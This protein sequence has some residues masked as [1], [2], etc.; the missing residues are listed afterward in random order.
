MSARTVNAKRT[1][2]RVRFVHLLCLTV[3]LA[4]AGSPPAGMAYADE[5]VHPAQP[6]FAAV[7]EATVE[8]P[9]NIYGHGTGFI[10]PRMELP[11]LTGQTMPETFLADGAPIELPMSFDW[12][13][14]GKVTSVKNQGVC[15]SCYAFAA[16]ANIE[17]EILIDGAAMLPDPDY[18]ENNAKECNWRELNDFINRFGDPVGGCD[19]GNYR[20]LAS[21]FSQTGIV[22]EACDPYVAG[23]SEPC[24]CSCP[25]EKTLLDWRII[26]GG[27]VADTTLLKNY[28]YQQASPVYV[29]I[30]A[31]SDYDPAWKAEFGLYDGSYTLYYPSCPYG[32][33]HAVLIVG[34]DD[35]LVHDGGTGGW[36]VKNSWGTSWGGDCGYGSEGGYFT[37]AYGSANIGRSASYMAEWQDYD[38][39]GGIL[40]YDDDC[41][42]DGAWRSGSAPTTTWGLCEFTPTSSTYATRVEFWTTD[43]TTDIDVYL[44]DDFDGVDLDNSNLLWSSLNHS[45]EEAG[46][47]GIDVAPPVPISSAAGITAV[48]AFTNETFAYPIAC[49]ARG[50]VETSR[51]YIS[52]DGS[53]D[54]WYDTGS[55]EDHASD[56]GIRVR[57][58]DVCDWGD[59]PDEPYP[60]LHTDDGA[61]HIVVN[62]FHLGATI[63]REGD[64]QP[65]ADATGDDSDGSDDDDGVV[66]TS[67]YLP[68]HDMTL[69]VAASQAGY[70][71]AW[72][73]FNADGDWADADEQVFASE[74]LAQGANSLAFSVPEGAST[75]GDI[76][77]R[78]RFSSSGGLSYTGEAGDGE[79]EDYVGFP[80]GIALSLE[81]GWN[82]VSTPVVPD[83]DSPEALFPCAEAIYA[84]APDTH[85][86]L[87]VSA[88]G[89]LTTIEPER[90]YWVALTEDATLI[91]TGTPVLQMIDYPL[92]TGWSMV[93]SIHGQTVG[94]A[95]LAVDPPGAIQ[96]ESIY[97]WNPSTKSFI[98]ASEIEPGKGYWIAASEPCNLTM[99]PP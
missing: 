67:S 42:D 55:D 82:M 4:A 84:W 22:A 98:P 40:Y 53:A 11:H 2:R 75:A 3:V 57:T 50:T 88:T 35:S 26:S 47:H 45:F 83:D 49:D 65:N 70:L 15:G 51:C 28:I 8:S 34:W 38:E 39:H 59:A 20:M 90:A 71:D 54:S 99:A 7:R 9:P 79:V 32:T 77:S 89:D 33:N 27:S 60:T 52:G 14:K 61:R 66:F 21:L 95:E 48:V 68:G 63:D 44:Y 6:R 96:I 69:T 31:G 25:Y 17:S 73:D 19:G 91:I 10:P 56:L 85:S 74:P 18:S 64:G 81:A 92:E 12:R 94:V 62:G 87:T 78:F 30:F 76:F 80:N 58:S 36:I 29:S 24:D 97:T 93:G 46:Y 72:V 43:I 5:P 37:I 86:Y 13:T 16:I 23:D 41:A 1:D